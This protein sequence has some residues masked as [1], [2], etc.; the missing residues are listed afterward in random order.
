M[1]SVII[2]IKTEP[3]IKTAA[4][5][6][7]ADLGLSLSGVINAYL[8]Q[9]IRDKKVR[10]SLREEPTEYLL[11]E[12]KKAEDDIKGG[13]VYSFDNPEDALKFLDK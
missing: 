2:N 12:I 13:N 8:R 3:K 9:L 6:I 1:N 7:A 5:K 11:N 10:F 4:Q